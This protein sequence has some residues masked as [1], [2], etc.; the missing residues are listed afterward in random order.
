MQHSKFL[1]LSNLIKKTKLG[2]IEDQYKMVSPERGA[3]LAKKHLGKTPRKAAVLALFYPN[4]EGVTCLALTL[5]PKYQGTHSAQV[6]FPGG[7]HETA[8][9][10]LAET[11]LRET[12]EEVGIEKKEIRILREVTN[13]YIPPS[14]F[15]VTPFIGI[16]QNTPIFKHNHEVEEL[17]EVPLSDLLDDKSI[18][19]K[20][21]KTFY[22][23]NVKV[24]Y[25]LFN[26]HIVWGATAMIISEI[27]ELLKR[28]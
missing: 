8:D 18:G 28:L 21:K 20:N 22:A 4:K 15:M 14:N 11:A 7:K 1:N 2:G 17:I 5:R 10:N 24:P 3:E 27:K 26:N 13:V 9:T 12:Y 19:T 16:T 25:F 6:S 23:E